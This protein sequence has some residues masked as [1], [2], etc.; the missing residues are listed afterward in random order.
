MG[1]ARDPIGY[2]FVY[3]DLRLKSRLVVYRR[4]VGFFSIEQ[5]RV[6]VEF[7]SRHSQIAKE[8]EKAVNVKTIIAG[9]VGVSGRSFSVEF[10]KIAGKVREGK[11]DRQI[12]SKIEFCGKFG[13]QT[14]KNRS[15]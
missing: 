11:E 9:R 3:E 2:F 10:T 14:S 8:R 7:S 4:K 13:V 5:R 12:D 6:R 1:C 15:L